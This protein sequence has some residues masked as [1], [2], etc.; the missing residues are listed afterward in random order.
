MLTPQ[1]TYYRVIDE[2][3]LDADWL[4]FMFQSPTF[5]AQLIQHGRQSTR[6]FVGITAQRELEIPFCDL[7]EQRAQLAKLR[8]MEQ[9]ISAAEQRKV[10]LARIQ[11]KML[12][13][14]F[15]S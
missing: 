12:N 7:D 9:A 13:E 10:I 5:Q 6:A 1:V 8:N 11:K 2:N 14:S 15:G 3:I 4:F